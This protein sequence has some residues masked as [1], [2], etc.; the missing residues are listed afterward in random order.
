M[1][2]NYSHQKFIDE[3]DI[4]D[5]ADRAGEVFNSLHDEEDTKGLVS[6]LY[7]VCQ[8][9][10]DKVDQLENNLTGTSKKLPAQ[11]GSKSTALNNWFKDKLS[12]AGFNMMDKAGTVEYPNFNINIDECNLFDESQQHHIHNQMNRTY[13]DLKDASNYE[14]KSVVA[15]LMARQSM[16]ERYIKNLLLKR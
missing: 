13:Q 2:T 16:N 1:E 10:A 8:C 9:L 15:Y 11:S 4:N 5:L 7:V 12:K 6:T 14:L 3:F